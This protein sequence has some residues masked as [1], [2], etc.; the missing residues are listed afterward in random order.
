MESK[1]FPRVDSAAVISLTPPF[2]GPVRKFSSLGWVV[3]V[4]GFHNLWSSHVFQS[5]NPLGVSFKILA[6][7]PWPPAL[8]T[9][10]C[11]PST[12][13]LPARDAQN[14]TKPWRLNMEKKHFSWG[15]PGP[16]IQMWFFQGC[17]LNFKPKCCMKT[18]F[19]TSDVGFRSVFDKSH[20]LTHFAW[21]FEAYK[22]SIQLIRIFCRFAMLGPC[23][24]ENT[25]KA[26]MVLVIFRTMDCWRSSSH[27]RW[28][29]NTTI[30]ETG[31]LFTLFCFRNAL[32]PCRNL[33]HANCRKCRCVSPRFLQSSIHPWSLTAPPL[34]NDAWKTILSFWGPAN[35]SA[36]TF[37]PQ[38]P[39]KMQ[40]LSPKHMLSY[41]LQLTPKKYRTSGFS[42]A[43]L[44][45]KMDFPNKCPQKISCTN[46]VNFFTGSPF[47]RGC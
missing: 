14:S 4:V 26:P 15:V 20:S 8:W 32:P 12:W 40:V 28:T 29:W 47:S 24:S 19:F 7:K 22:V 46:G 45:P 6:L 41:K 5:P 31:S 36:T 9:C 27:L 37:E 18:C 38:N 21:I 23:L 17:C 39:W 42:L 10:D 44:P 11:A 3:A 35:F 25:S 34:E 43:S 30:S 13:M 33:N 1:K 2:T 16:Q